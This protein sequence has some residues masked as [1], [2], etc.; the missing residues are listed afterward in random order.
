M[1]NPSFLAKQVRIMLNF[2]DRGQKKKL[3][4][5]AE[6][7]SQKLIKAIERLKESGRV[8]CKGCWNIANDFQ[9]SK[10]E[11]ANAYEKLNIKILFCQL[12][13]F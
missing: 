9:I 6:N 12:G 5:E 3:V 13:A 7:V 10:I 2:L 8:P 4:K 11:V 1:Y